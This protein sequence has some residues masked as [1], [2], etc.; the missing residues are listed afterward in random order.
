MHRRAL[1][2]FGRRPD[3]AGSPAGAF[4]PGWPGAAASGLEPPAWAGAR[5]YAGRPARRVHPVRWR[6][7]R[8]RWWGTGGRRGR[9]RE[10]SEEHFLQP[11]R[12]GTAAHEPRPT[13]PPGRS[14]PAR[15][16]PLY[17]RIRRPD[18]ARSLGYSCQELSRRISAAAP[19]KTQHL[20]NIVLVCQ[21]KHVLVAPG[22]NRERVTNVQEK[23]VGILVVD[24]GAFSQPRGHD[25]LDEERIAHTS[26]CFLEVPLNQVRK[27]PKSR[28]PP[29]L[30]RND[31]I[32][33]QPR[34]GPPIGQN[35]R[36]RFLHNL[37]VTRDNSQVKQGHGRRK[38]RLGH[39]PAVLDGSHRVIK[40]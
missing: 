16:P 14:Q 22:G 31:V 13:P 17:V 39:S 3:S 18:S 35:G 8:S 19:R 9:F 23:L 37:T 12:N 36:R 26:G 21:T 7:R 24:R 15:G 33:T 27:P 4:A 30:L 29:P 5:S 6:R 10:R 38:V 34:S 2:G 40:L 25:G 20:G 1:G 11:R 32:E 28:A